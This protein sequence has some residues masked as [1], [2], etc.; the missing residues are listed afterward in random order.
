VGAH[1]PHAGPTTYST[2]VRYIPSSS[3]PAN[4]PLLGAE[5]VLGDTTSFSLLS[6]TWWCC[7]RAEPLPA[8]RCW[9]F[10]G[11]A[12]AH[13]C[14]LRTTR[15]HEPLLR[16]THPVRR[17]GSARDDSLSLGRSYL[18]T[19]TTRHSQPPHDGLQQQLC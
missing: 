15:S 11:A 19:A 18:P 4:T 3:H 16:P 13:S 2:G 6:F 17:M 9:F 8:W 12:V 1:D 10:A 14:V 5:A 7:L